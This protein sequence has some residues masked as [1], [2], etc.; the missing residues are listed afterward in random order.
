MRNIGITSFL[1][2][3]ILSLRG[4]SLMAQEGY[5]E[6]F[7]YECEYATDREPLPGHM[8]RVGFISSTRYGWSF[9]FPDERIQSNLQMVGI[10]D[11]AGLI[12][13]GESLG[14]WQMRTP[15]GSFVVA[16]IFVGDQEGEP[17]VTCL[18]RPILLSRY[19]PKYYGFSNI[20]LDRGKLGY[21]L[22]WRKYSR[23]GWRDRWQGDIYKIRNNFSE[24][25]DRYKDRYNRRRLDRNNDRYDRRSDRYRDRDDRR[26][27]RDGDHARRNRDDRRWISRR[28]RRGKADIDK[29]TIDKSLIPTNEVGGR[30]PD[31]ESNLPTVIKRRGR[32]I[33]RP[34]Q[35]VG[36]LQEAKKRAEGRV[37]NFKKNVAK[38]LQREA[39]IVRQRGKKVQGVSLPAVGAAEIKKKIVRSSVEPKKIAD[40]RSSRSDRQSEDND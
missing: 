39:S 19:V 33:E 37:E 11:S 5:L 34:V 36:D 10:S 8:L 17:V 29:A 21:W 14:E 6:S 26:F 23:W 13:S 15:P 30:T 12:G 4:G 18:S 2:L 28:D 16:Q 25:R 22:K 38:E 32:K 3:M 40:R 27:D 7:P 35:S 24:Y 1:F 31:S 20:W 9:F